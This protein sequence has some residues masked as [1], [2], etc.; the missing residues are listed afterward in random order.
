MNEIPYTAETHIYLKD[1]VHRKLTR[2]NLPSK[3]S[4]F[5]N[6]LTMFNTYRELT[7]CLRKQVDENSLQ[8]VIVFNNL[9]E[10]VCLYRGANKEEATTGFWAI[11]VYV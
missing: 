7:K 9:P 4:D 10:L 6:A 2:A 11:L 1:G 8:D 5:H 3:E